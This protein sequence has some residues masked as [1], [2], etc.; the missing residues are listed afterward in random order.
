MPHS[1]RPPLF[2]GIPSTDTSGSAAPALSASQ[3]LELRLRER[4]GA[5][6]L[7]QYP[8][9]LYGMYESSKVRDGQL[10]SLLHA[11]CQSHRFISH[12]QLQH[13]PSPCGRHQHC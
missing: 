1:S 8:D 6:L 11:L 5:A 13:L 10:C 2:L 9:V 7:H 12:A 4:G 3:A